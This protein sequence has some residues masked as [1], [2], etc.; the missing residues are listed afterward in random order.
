MVLV[1][2]RPSFTTM[3][4]NSIRKKLAVLSKTSGHCYYCGC[5]L[6]VD[7]VCL[8][9]VLAKSKGGT[10]ELHNLVP[11]CIKCNSSKGTKSIDEFRRHLACPVKFTESQMNLLMDIGC[12]DR[13]NLYLD[14]QIEE[15]K[16]W[17]ETHR[18]T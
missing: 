13:V 8:D 5:N 18:I 4:P 11:C 15:F 17:Y 10:R 7:S 16:F 1:P 3:K 14:R 6:T 12:Y 2:P 9:H